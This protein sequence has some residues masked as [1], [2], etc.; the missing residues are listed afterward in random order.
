MPTYIDG[1]LAGMGTSITDKKYQAKL[2]EKTQQAFGDKE[3][4]KRDELLSNKDI[5]TA[6]KNLTAEGKQKFDQILSMDDDA[7][8]VSEKEYKTLMT[9]LD[10][11]LGVNTFTNQETFLMDG[12]ISTGE[13]G[14]IYQATNQEIQNVH[15]N[16]KTRAE[17]K[18]QQKAKEV[19]KMKKMSNVQQAINH[20][21]IKSGSGL[22]H[23][24][25]TVDKNFSAVNHDRDSYKEYAEAIQ[26]VFGD[27]LESADSLR[28]GGS[29]EY[30]L[31]DGTRIFH[32]HSLTGNEQGYVTITRPDGTVEKYSPDGERAN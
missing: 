29:R 30:T 25:T 32:N 13:K 23:V 9:I 2:S 24:L 21:D 3:Q 15:D 31:K 10:A 22:T 5:Y 28:D 4:I 18:A 26:M 20:N 12:E 27:N 1:K 17:V 14:G 19:A 7:S 6:Y 8:T 16:I 11:D